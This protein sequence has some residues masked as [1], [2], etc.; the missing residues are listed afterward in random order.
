MHACTNEYSQV[1]VHAH[2]HALVHV[3]VLYILRMHTVNSLNKRH[4]T[5]VFGQGA[6]FAS[7]IELGSSLL[8]TFGTES[9]YYSES[10]LYIEG[11]QRCTHLG[12]RAATL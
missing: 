1:H 7:S 11:V 10:V 3:H 5:L 8:H 2:V 4:F 6:V 9:S 12:L